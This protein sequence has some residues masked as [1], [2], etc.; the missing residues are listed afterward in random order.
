MVRGQYSTWGV[1]G[2]V[3]ITACR[4]DKADPCVA[5]PATCKIDPCAAYGGVCPDPIKIN[6]LMP[7]NDGAWIDEAY[8]ADDWVEVINTGDSPESLLGYTISDRL[9]RFYFLPAKILRPGETL[10]VWADNTPTQG[11]NHLAFKLSSAGE[12]VFL[13]APDSRL[14]DRISYD[15]MATNDSIARIPDGT[16]EPTL[17]HWATPGRANGEL[18]GP[19]PPTEIPPDVTF[20]PYTWADPTPALATPLALTELALKPASFVEVLNTSDAPVDLTQYLLTVSP[21]GPGLPWP[22]ANVGV[23][24]YWQAT[25]LAPGE[26]ALVAVDSSATTDLVLD[27]EF[28]G[29]VTLWHVADGAVVDR[30]DFMAWPE[31]AVL[32]RFPEPAGAMRFCAVVTPGAANTTCEPLASRPLVDRV[33]HFYTPGDFAA[34]AQGGVALGMESVEFVVDMDM[35]DVVHFLSAAQWDLHYT[36][37]RE[38]IDHQPHLNRCDPTE[39]QLFYAGWVQF[40]QQQYFTVDGRRYL[41]GTLVRHAGSDLHSVEFALGDRITGPMMLRAFF[42][43]TAHVDEPTRWSMRPQSGQQTSV[44]LGI[45][46]RAPI[47]DGNAPFRGV[48]L[49][50][51]ALGI[52]YGILTFVPLEEL[53]S[54]AL[55]PQVVVVTDQV[56]NDIPLVG[57]LITEAFQTPLAHV[58]ILSQNRGTPNMALKNARTDP[59]VVPFFD[60]LVRLEVKP[61]AF[62]LRTADPLEAETFWQSQHPA[63]DP[64]VPRLDTSVRG[65]Q[66]LAG[67]SLADLPAIGAKAAGLAELARVSSALAGCP[68]PLALPQSPFA[69]PVVHSLEHFE[70][71][72]ARALLAGFEADPTFR[73]DP[74]VRAQKLAQVQALIKSAPIDLA[75]VSAVQTHIAATFGNVRM[76]FRSSSNTEDLDGFNGAGLYT[77]FSADID[78]ADLPIADAIRAVWA[79]LYNARAYDERAYF[80]VDGA[81][82]AMAVLVHPTFVSERANGVGISRDITEPIRS[83]QYYLNIQVG[84]ASVTNPAPGVTTDQMIYR[85]GNSAKIDYLAHTN[86]P[87]ANPILS[88]P[89]ID[90]IACSLRAIHDHFR[91][92][93]DPTDDN[94][95]FAMDVELKVIGPERRLVFKQ[96]RPYGFGKAQIPADCREF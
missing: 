18:C 90:R 75:L 62:T 93:I 63:G 84:E 2:L 76:R 13:W 83:D 6:E 26:R 54:A 31:G 19:P 33:R 58:N 55:G 15:A 9:D 12:T 21:H 1:L 32:A 50:P 14:V 41:L 7:D 79:S 44:M 24:L 22:L 20:A 16:G 46:G 35:G 95:W 48:T 53:D 23:P 80:N 65:V 10:L 56:P 61:G 39:A 59:R 47:V 68:G 36:W 28:E 64:L 71:S 52:A 67:R 3:A 94:R 8:E 29:V 60:T 92:L 91:P 49:Q 85:W 5:D 34:L 40:S 66:P 88:E 43:V 30:V 74:R 81:A 4:A 87:Y 78:A 27:P 77:S 17:C 25:A 37:I 82:T 89:E 42:G 70:A 11:G 72:G 73:A 86:L 38:T 96:A 45:D 69:I 57:G 51:L